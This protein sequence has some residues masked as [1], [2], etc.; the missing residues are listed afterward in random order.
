VDVEKDEQP[1]AKDRA[2]GPWHE[3]VGVVP[4]MGMSR[5]D[6]PKIA[7]IYHPLAPSAV[8]VP[9]H[10]GIHVRGD[11]RTFGPRLR[12]IAAAVDPTLRLDAILPMAELS[13]ASARFLDFWFRL[14]LLVSVMAVVLSLAGIY[15]VM[16]FTVARRTREI[17]IRVALG[18]SAPR[19]I[20]SV[21]ARPLTQV[22]VGVA[23]GGMLAGLLL[24]G[25]TG[26][27]PS[28]TGAALLAAYAALMLGVCLLACIAPT[29]RALRVQP[30]QALRVDG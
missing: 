29:R 20:A 2:P 26:G 8:T 6:D 23:V 18:A 12:A 11:P 5:P 25:M 7:G 30:T 17:G 9:L 3:I 15:A 27:T 1:Y 14:T 16:S 19:V 24:V 10:M 22:G 21:F 28:V 13:Q 4:D